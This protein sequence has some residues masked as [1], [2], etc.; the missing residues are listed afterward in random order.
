MVVLLFPRPTVAGG[1]RGLDL[2]GD[3]VL[4][5]L[6]DVVQL[7]LPFRLAGVGPGQV[8]VPP[9]QRDRG[10]RLAQPDQPFRRRRVTRPARQRP[11]VKAGYLLAAA[12]KVV[13]PEG[14]QRL[15]PLACLTAEAQTDLVRL[16]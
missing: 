14:R 16:E 5:Q 12:V 6:A 10:Q 4:P 7:P 2:L 13:P 15:K 1:E 11:L 9:P 3:P 8:D